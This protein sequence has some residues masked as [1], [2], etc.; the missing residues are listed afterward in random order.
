MPIIPE[1]V[2]A[3]HIYRRNESFLAKAIEGLTA[4]QWQTR[5]G[6]SA[7]SALWIVGHMV[8]A[9]SRVLK[10]LGVSWTA[11]W[12]PLFE[13]GSKP[14]DPAQY[15]PSEQVLIA[16]NELAAALPPALE[17]AS[18]ADIAAPAPEPSPSFDG[19]IG[20]MVSF[21]AMHETYHVGQVVYLRRLL[22]HERVTG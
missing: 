1:L 2:T 8:W 9:R 19:T 5:P 17:S 16:W 13:R 7:N 4:E 12:L 14:V 10:L 11:P 22:G 21:L 3:A 18:A 20:G 6:D 15:P